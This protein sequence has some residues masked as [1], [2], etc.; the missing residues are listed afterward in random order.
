[1]RC[2][3]D[4]VIQEISSNVYVNDSYDEDSDNQLSFDV[5]VSLGSITFKE[6]R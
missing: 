1:M 3:I 5:D 2:S 4:E 6:K